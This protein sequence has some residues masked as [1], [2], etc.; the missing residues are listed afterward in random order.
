M[1]QDSVKGRLKPFTAFSNIL[2]A[3]VS[4]VRLLFEVRLDKNSG[5]T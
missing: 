4:F 2:F 1:H 5:T 3:V